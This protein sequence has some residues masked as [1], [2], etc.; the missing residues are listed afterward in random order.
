MASLKDH[1]S[2]CHVDIMVICQDFAPEIMHYMSLS[3]TCVILINLQTSSVNH[4][5]KILSW[6]QISLLILPTSHPSIHRRVG[7]IVVSIVFF[8]SYSYSFPFYYSLYN[9]FWSKFKLREHLQEEHKELL[10][11]LHLAS[12][13]VYILPHLP[14]V[15]FLVNT[16]NTWLSFLFF[17]ITMGNVT[18][19]P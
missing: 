18:P 15:S 5:W 6:H 13:T 19:P 10:D 3:I 2:T 17:W 12:P 14:H 11:L 9:L 4:F 7:K 8:F 1:L 16:Y